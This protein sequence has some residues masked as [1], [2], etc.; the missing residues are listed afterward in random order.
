[1]S[2]APKHRKRGFK[3]SSSLEVSEG[4]RQQELCYHKAGRRDLTLL[5]S[6]P[7]S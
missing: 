4:E 1:M 5:P 6:M 3:R 2:A 7:V